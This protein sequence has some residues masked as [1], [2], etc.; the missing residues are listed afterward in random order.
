MEDKISKKVWY[1]DALQ[2]CIKLSGWVLVPL[3][4]GYT[5]GRYLD[6]KYQSE[7]KWFFISIGIAFI[8][9]TIGIVYQAQIEYKKINL[10][11]K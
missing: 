1:Y 7:P 8:L 5:L 9:S 10:P 4:V 11:K 6:N 2:M 3:I